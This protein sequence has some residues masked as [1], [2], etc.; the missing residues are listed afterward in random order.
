MST[1]RILIVSAIVSLGA[2]A[3]YGVSQSQA[4]IPT[5]GKLFN[6][7]LVP[8]LEVPVLI[9]APFLEAEPM[10]A[11]TRIAGTAANRGDR[12][13][14]LDCSRQTWPMISPDCMQG[15][16]PAR[17]PVRTITVETRTAPA[18]SVLT[19]VPARDVTRR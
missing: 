2:V 11:S 3:A 10:P 8:E 6:D 9:E 15:D 18:T 16:A 13:A 4:M 19:R 14:G 1:L 12:V 7:R 17:K 5:G